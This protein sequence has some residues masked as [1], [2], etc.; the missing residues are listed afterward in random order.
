MGPV[1]KKFLADVKK[2]TGYT[3][4]V[5][6]TKRTRGAK[7]TATVTIGTGRTFF[8]TYGQGP[9]VAEGALLRD[10]W[11]KADELITD[12]RATLENAYDSGS[13]GATISRIGSIH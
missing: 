1:L 5:E 2:A 11:A 4:S 8:P 7:T 9:I 6:S 12:Y 3:L 13:T 10:A